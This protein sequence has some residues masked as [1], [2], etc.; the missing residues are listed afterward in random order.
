M[1]SF[2]AKR[3]TRGQVLS[4]S[5]KPEDVFPL[6]GPVREKEWAEAWQINPIYT[7]TELAE[8]GFIFTTKGHSGGEVIWVMTQY[9][10]STLDLEYLVISPGLRVVKLHVHCEADSNDPNCDCATHAVVT[11]TMTAL[12]EHGNISVDQFTEESFRDDMA[13]WEKAINHYLKTGEPLRHH[14]G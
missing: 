10:T 13:L 14:E 1:S 11:R 3:V 2:K 6:F 12:S 7:E 5:G 8:E 9:A 4:L